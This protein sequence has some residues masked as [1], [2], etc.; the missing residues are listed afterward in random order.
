MYVRTAATLSNISLY[1]LYMPHPSPPHR[2]CPAFCV[3]FTLHCQSASIL[4]HFSPPFP[5]TVLL[6]RLSI[7]PEFFQFSAHA[8]SC[9]VCLSCWPIIVSGNFQ[10]GWAEGGER[11]TEN[12][13]SHIISWAMA[14]STYRIWYWF[15][16]F[17]HLFDL[18]AVAGAISPVIEEPSHCG[19][20][21]ICSQGVLAFWNWTQSD[22]TSWD[23]QAI[24]WNWK[25]VKRLQQWGKVCWLQIVE[26]RVEGNLLD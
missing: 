15:H 4:F 21:S 19:R 17:W 11:R 10:G 22:N 2:N 7:F 20:Y 13:N 6:F 26:I 18:M 9:C 8:A 23:F 16:S 24:T 1:M 5:H 25:R 3:L 12:S 14:L